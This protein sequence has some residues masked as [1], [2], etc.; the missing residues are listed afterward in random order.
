ME[1]AGEGEGVSAVQWG[2][3]LGCFLLL[4]LGDGE[5]GALGWWA[6]SACLQT[7]RCCFLS[8]RKE[9][10]DPDQLYNTLKNLLAQIK[11]QTG[12]SPPLRGACP[13]NS[14]RSYI[15]WDR[16]SWALPAGGQGG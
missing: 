3:G 7:D 10:K 14:P 2:L 12:G 6:Q 16:L 9:L 8:R 4:G 1:T 13:H 5:V 11:V 15:P